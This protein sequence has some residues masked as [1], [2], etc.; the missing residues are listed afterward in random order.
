MRR[1]MPKKLANRMGMG[2]SFRETELQV[3]AFTPRVPVHSLNCP[4]ILFRTAVRCATNR[5]GVSLFRWTH[6]VAYPDPVPDFTLRK[7]LTHLW[8]I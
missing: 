2:K 1:K 4:A 3:P 6:R 5:A 8:N 7:S